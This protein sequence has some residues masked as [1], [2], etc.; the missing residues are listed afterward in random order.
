[1]NYL[2]QID[3]C[4]LIG[5]WVVDVMDLSVQEIRYSADKGEEPQGRDDLGGAMEARHSVRIQG[6]TDGQIPELI[7]IVK[8]KFQAI[9]LI[10]FWS[11]IC[12]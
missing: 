4:Y 3:R 7:N 6:V 1:M 11:L 2:R 5:E 9:S 12:G 10:N 8:G